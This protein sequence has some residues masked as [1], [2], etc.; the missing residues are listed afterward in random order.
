MLSVDRLST[1]G[2][3][4]CQVQPPAQPSWLEAVELAL[5]VKPNFGD[6]VAI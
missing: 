6:L 3:A 5:L 2:G 4:E 1:P